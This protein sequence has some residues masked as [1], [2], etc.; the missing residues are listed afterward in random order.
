[1]V[2]V[3]SGTSEHMKLEKKRYRYD[4]VSMCLVWGWVGSIL[5]FKVGSDPSSV[6]LRGLGPTQFFVW[7]EGCKGIGCGLF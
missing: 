5:V 1:M 4:A 7:S 3:Y 2:L 6:W